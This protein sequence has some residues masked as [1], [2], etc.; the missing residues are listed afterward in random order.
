MIMQNLWLKV[1][2]VISKLKKYPVRVSQQSHDEGNN[3]LL[4]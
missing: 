4:S 2:I 1:N 3:T